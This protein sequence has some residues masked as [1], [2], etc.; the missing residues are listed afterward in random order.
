MGLLDAITNMGHTPAHVRPLTPGDR[1]YL[2]FV[3]RNPGEYQDIGALLHFDGPPLDLPA[4]RAHVAERLRDPRARMLTDRLDTVRVWSP[5]RGASAEETR[6]VS[7]PDMNLDDHVVAFDLPPADGAAA[8]GQAADASH[9]ARLRAAVDAIVARPIDLTRPPWML[10]LLRDPTPGATGTA[11]VY[12]SSHV[13]QDGFALYR[14]MYLLFGESDEVDLG[15]AP[16]IRRP[17]PADYARFV[18]RGISCLL[19][20]RR[21]ESWGGPPSGPARHTWVTTEL[22]TLR[23]VARR[24]GVTVNDVYLAALAGALRAWSLPEWERSGR[25]VHALMPISIRSAAEQD[26]LS[27]HST[28][29]RVPL[30]CGEPD[31]ARRVAMI[32]AETRRMK[33]GGLGLVE[34]HHFPLM[35]AKATQ[36]MLANVGSYPAQINKM[37]LVA[38]N[39]RSIRGPLSIAGRR[40][41]GLIGMGPLLVGRQHLAVAMFGVDDRVGVTFVASESVPDHARLAD[42]WLAELAALGRSDS[43]VGVSVPTQRL[44]S[45]SAAVTAVMAG[46]GPGAV[47]G[48]VSGAVTGA[49]RTEVGA[50]IRPWRRRPTTPAAPAM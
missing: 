3:R 50:L 13:Q 25:Q 21:L 18:G 49:V 8:A 4:L 32:A 11:L 6:W 43:P 42:L 30:F 15:L 40:M 20:T 10:Y 24:H 31:P 2:A 16:T 36:R 14:V 34:R 9:D 41:T 26:V 33:Q 22:A 38:T 23:A 29:A 28:G 39:A 37:A 5:E 47:S 48:A 7:D 46:A 45:A 17:R 44:S 19:P 27:N 12:R 35:A 1:A